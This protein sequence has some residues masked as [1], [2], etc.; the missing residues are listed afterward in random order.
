MF[1]KYKLDGEELSEH[2][3]LYGAKTEDDALVLARIWFMRLPAYIKDKINPE[4]IWFC[5][6]EVILIDFSVEYDSFFVWKDKKG[7]LLAQACTERR[8]AEKLRSKLERKGLSLDDDMWIF[9]D[10]GE[11]YEDPGFL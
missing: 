6:N 4:D 3:A 9:L 11:L 1:I 5:G 2:V 7:R 10:S 8:Q